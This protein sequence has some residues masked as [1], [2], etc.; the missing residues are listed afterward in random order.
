MLKKSLLFAA[1]AITLSASTKPAQFPLPECFP[2]VVETNQFPLPECF[3][4]AVETSQFPLPEC[5]PCLV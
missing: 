4:C 1:V 2:C 3:P 5:F